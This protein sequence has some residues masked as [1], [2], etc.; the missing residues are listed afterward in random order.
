MVKH[1]HTIRRQFAE[2]NCFSMFDYFLELP[3]CR[4]LHAA[5]IRN[6]SLEISYL[7]IRIWSGKIKKTPLL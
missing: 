4:Y 6:F 2:T 5:A 7:E 3:P 1:T